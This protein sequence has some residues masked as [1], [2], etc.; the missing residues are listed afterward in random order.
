MDD[1][2]SFPPSEQTGS[3]PTAAGLHHSA[4]LDDMLAVPGREP[5]ERPSALQ[6]H[7][8]KIV[9][10]GTDQQVSEGFAVAL[11]IMGVDASFLPAGALDTN[12][13]NTEDN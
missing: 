2:R 9:Y 10:C 7:N 12:S 3:V 5:V 13:P 6:R 8:S 11:R 1:G 4:E